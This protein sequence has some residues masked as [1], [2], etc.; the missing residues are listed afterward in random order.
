MRK[1]QQALAILAVCLPLIVN[2][3]AVKSALDGYQLAI[4]WLTIV[5]A[6]AVSIVSGLLISNLDEQFR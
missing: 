4:P 5:I 2:L 3:V 6:T 1:K